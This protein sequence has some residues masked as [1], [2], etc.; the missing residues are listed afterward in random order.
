MSHRHPI[1]VETTSCV[2][3]VSTVFLQNVFMKFR[4][5]FTL[6]NDLKRSLD[7][8]LKKQC[9]RRHADRSNQN[10][11]FTLSKKHNYGGTTQPCIVYWGTTNLTDEYSPTKIVIKTFIFVE[12]GTVL[13]LSKKHRTIPNTKFPLFQIPLVGGNVLQ[14]FEFI[15]SEMNLVNCLMSSTIIKMSHWSF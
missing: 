15:T 2:S 5:V 11:A 7:D 10:W 1:D 3:W 14:N 4:T 8:S 6:L 9:F 13:L 12:F